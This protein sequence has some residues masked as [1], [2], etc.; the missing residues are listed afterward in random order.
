[1]ISNNIGLYGGKIV[2]DLLRD[3]IY[4]PAWWYGRGLKQVAIGL[5]NFLVNKERS[6]ALFVWIKNIFRPMYA[7]YDWAG[8]L[9]SFFVRL[10]QIIVR[11]IF[12][13]FWLALALL[14][15][16]LWLVLPILAIYEI[17]FQLAL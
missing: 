6:L 5:K 17:I 10:F 1:M 11:G 3:I 2:L 7:Q 9:I 13:L 4:F 15:L 16:G 8:I 14:I 12:M